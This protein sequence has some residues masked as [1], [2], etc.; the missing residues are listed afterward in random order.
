MA[1]RC[2]ALLALTCTILCIHQADAQK[3]IAVDVNTDEGSR[4]LITI[5]E[6]CT[7]TPR[8]SSGVFLIH[9][10][11]GF[12][13]PFFVLCDHEYESGGWTVIQNRFD[14][15]VNFL[16]SWDEFKKGFGH[17][18]REFWLGLDRIHQLTYAK[19]HE[20]HIVLED[21]EAERRVAKYSSF[22]VAGEAE[23][24]KLIELGKYSGTAGDSFRKHKNCLFST[25][26]RDNDNITDEHCAQVYL[27]AWWHNDCFQSHL[28][29]QYL[30]GLTNSFSG[31]VWNSFRGGR[32]SLKVSRMLVRIP[33][34]DKYSL[35]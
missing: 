12:G 22:A 21:F 9:P 33:V 3:T 1:L 24:Y 8:N 11:K 16:R 7:D 4:K 13:E 34:D 30:K 14:G 19:A 25:I 20:L 15:S 18:N 6:T 29:G 17:L 32:Y 10:E 31:M 2:L 5:P 23:K 27:G 26:D 35:I 28:N